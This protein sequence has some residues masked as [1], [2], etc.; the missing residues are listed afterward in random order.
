MGHFMKL[1]RKGLIISLIF[2]IVILTISAIL[3]ILLFP[4]NPKDEFDY[5]SWITVLSPLTG[6]VLSILITVFF[7]IDTSEFLKFRVIYLVLGIFAY[8]F[9]ILNAIGDSML[10]LII[11]I[12]FCVVEYLYVIKKS[13]K[14]SKLIIVILSDPIVYYIIALI[15]LISSL[16]FSNGIMPAFE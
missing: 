6:A 12:I 8:C 14:L 10:I 11:P 16:D 2:P 5:L 15:C 4:Y 3:L 9:I 13:G 7:S 1:H